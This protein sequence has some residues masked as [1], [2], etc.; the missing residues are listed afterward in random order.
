MVEQQSQSGLLSYTLESTCTHCAHVHIHITQNELN[1]FC[2]V[3]L[4]FMKDWGDGSDSKVPATQ[5]ENMSLDLQ[6]PCKNRDTAVAPELR[7]GWGADRQIPGTQWPA[8]L[9]ES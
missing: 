4:E 1:H 6:H 2:T 3:S 7:W 9:A 8:R 5:H